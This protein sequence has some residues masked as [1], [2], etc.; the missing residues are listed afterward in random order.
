MQEGTVMSR[1]KRTPS[2]AK[3]VLP[4]GVEIPAG[5][6]TEFWLSRGYV[7]HECL[8]PVSVAAVDAAMKAAR[9]LG[10]VL[11]VYR[12]GTTA[13]VLVYPRKLHRKGK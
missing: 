7:L 11:V 2:A 4:A 1:K 3:A 9:K 12:G 5:G 13:Y 10:D 8:T 6:L